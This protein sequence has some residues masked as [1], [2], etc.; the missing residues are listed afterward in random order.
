MEEE[1]INWKYE[2]KYLAWILIFIVGIMI[3][4]IFSF[5]FI[6]YKP[7][8]I[9]ILENNTILLEAYTTGFQYCKDYCESM[10]LTGYMREISTIH[11]S[12]LCY[13]STDI[14]ITQ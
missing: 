6:I 8:N 4:Y 3:G 7:E 9:Q 14:T 13:N 1:N 12:C 2:K 11:H 10:N 5:Q